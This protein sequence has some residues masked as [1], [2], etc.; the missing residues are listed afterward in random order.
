M[1][2][3]VLMQQLAELEK[4]VGNEQVLTVKLTRITEFKQAHEYYE[5]EV[6]DPKAEKE[7]TRTLQSE[8]EAQEFAELC[9]EKGKLPSSNP[10]Q[11]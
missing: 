11:W 8:K 2:P 4:E 3:Y 5:V 7:T 9:L 1:Q 6:Y 10:V